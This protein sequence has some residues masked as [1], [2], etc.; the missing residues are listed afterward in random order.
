MEESI[1]GDRAGFSPQ[2]QGDDI[3]L[4]HNESMFLLM[5]PEKAS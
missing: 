2:L 5:R 1:S 3:V 4:A